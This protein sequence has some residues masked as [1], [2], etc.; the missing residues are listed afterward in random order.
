LFT[1]D[2]VAIL[3]YITVVHT[4][5]LTSLTC[6][7]LLICHGDEDLMKLHYKARMSCIYNDMINMVITLL[8][9]WKAV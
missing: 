5:L 4:S 2:G 6:S 1:F 3:K 8:V 7:P 9:A